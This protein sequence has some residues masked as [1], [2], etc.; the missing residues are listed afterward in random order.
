LVAGAGSWFDNRTVVAVPAVRRDELRIVG[1]TLDEITW[2]FVAGTGASER[3]VAP[4][5]PGVLFPPHPTEAEYV[6]EIIE[7][8]IAGHQW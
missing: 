4:F 3:I 7:W 8:P 5:P 6:A 2:E 1:A